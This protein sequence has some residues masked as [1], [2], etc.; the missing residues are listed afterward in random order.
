M[1]RCVL[2]CDHH[3]LTGGELEQFSNL[4]FSALVGG[5]TISLFRNASA[6]S[7]GVSGHMS[8]KSFLD[9]A[10]TEQQRYVDP[11]RTLREVTLRLAGIDH[12]Y[13][14]RG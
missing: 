1:P 8:S 13:V 3:N 7:F 2:V 14:G 9:L 6:G 5:K 4:S 12:F 11:N 10:Y